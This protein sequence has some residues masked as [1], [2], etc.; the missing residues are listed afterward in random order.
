MISIGFL[1]SFWVQGLP[2]GSRK[3]LRAMA[4]PER[5]QCFLSGL[6][7][8][9]HRDSQR[10]PGVSKRFSGHVSSY[11]SA[12]NSQRKFQELLVD[13]TILKSAALG[14]KSETP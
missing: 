1:K 5:L 12:H 8:L 13:A 6:S 2:I 7:L 14:K 3:G 9:V 4:L 10:F 11:Q